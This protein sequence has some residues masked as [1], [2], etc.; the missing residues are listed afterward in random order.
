[1]AEKHKL[2]AIVFTDIV[3]YTQQMDADE[4]LTMKVLERQKE[5]V[6]P[7]VEAHNGQVLKEIGDGLLIMFESAI[8][9]VRCVM[10]FQQELKTEE[11][12]VRAGI[13]IGDVIFKDGDVFGSAV[14]IAARIEPLAKA[15]GICVSE[16]VKNQL[17]NHKDIFTRGIG[18][19]ELKGVSEPVKIFEVLM[20]QPE[21]REIPKTSFWK[22]IWRRRVPQVIGAYIIVSAI[23]LLL[24]K[25]LIQQYALSPYLFQFALIA[26]VTLIPGIFLVTYLHGRPGTRQIRNIERIAIPA[27]LVITALLLF[28]LFRGTDLG[29]TTK[30]VTLTDED[31]EK[32]ER[33]IVKSEFRKN[34]L[35]FFFDNPDNDTSLNWLQ[36]GI[37]DMLEYKLYQDMYIHSISGHS[38]YIS[39]VEAG[40]PDG[41]NIPLTLKQ[42]FA[43][44]YHKNYFLAGS[45]GFKNDLYV[46]DYILYKTNTGKRA[47]E[48]TFEDENIFKIVDQL[49]A[50]LKL[51]L[52]LPAKHI[53]ETTDLPIS[54][55]YSNS[56]KA[57]SYHV[58]GKKAWT[59][60][61]DWQKMLHLQEMALKEDPSLAMAYVFILNACIAGN[62]RQKMEETFDILMTYRHKLPE[63]I[64]FEVRQAYYSIYKNDNE[65]AFSVVKMWR[66]LYPDDISVH[67]RM[68]EFYQQQGLLDKVI[69]E[70]KIV[71]QLDPERSEY[72]LRISDFY[73]RLQDYEQAYEYIDMYARKY[74]NNIRT[75]MEWGAYYRNTGDFHKAKEYYEK[76]L[77]I[78]PSDVAAQRRLAG[79]AFALGEFDEIEKMY[80]DILRISRSAEDSAL[81]YHSLATFYMVSGQ[82]EKSIDIKQLEYAAMAKYQMPTAINIT[83]AVEVGIYALAGRSEEGLEKIDEIKSN[84][85]PPF[86]QLISLAY[87]SLYTEMDNA[88]SIRNAVIPLEALIEK[89]KYDIILNFVYMAN[90]RVEELE[91]NYE[92]A[93]EY[94]LQIKELEPGSFGLNTRLGRCYRKAGQENK[95]EGYLLESLK[96]APADPEANLEMAFLY[97]QKGDSDKAMEYL[98]ISLRAWKNA[99]DDYKLAIQARELREVI[100]D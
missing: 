44:R 73:M 92:A 45:V 27:N 42:Q 51:D 59:F 28:F 94:Y 40:Y 17:R 46:V 76:A 26:L 98:D 78:D 71:L 35:I 41:V 66:D 10:A 38:I 64:Q 23:I 69:E 8:Q 58:R 85:I 6:F 7:V 68:S 12:S 16:E 99:D 79:V 83:R 21:T 89:M 30:S 91:G 75:Y 80:Q 88:D 84:L 74:P 82:I 15:N 18:E 19:K 20:E 100:S 65:K 53:E 4:Q 13:H 2:A 47:A 31:G 22:H 14:N 33:E 95:V 55:T 63:R 34:L 72:L 52:E 57:V 32:I 39:M 24:L 11:F 61:K 5:I 60:D 50:Q 67:L 96:I 25:W 3:G 90:G 56:V 49:E 37:S 93:A 29:A 70:W 97:H 48:G 54:D 9:A 77:L 81:V 43:N 87:I 86:D 1:M 36:Y 62:L